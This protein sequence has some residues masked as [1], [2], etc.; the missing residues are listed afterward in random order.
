VGVVE[1]E[2]ELYVMDVIAAWAKVLPKSLHV[3]PAGDLAFWVKTAD[4]PQ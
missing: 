4:L 2:T 3:L 1:A